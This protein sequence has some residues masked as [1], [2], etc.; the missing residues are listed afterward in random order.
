ML[1]VASG[2]SW[3]V[4]ES[5][6]GLT[7]VLHVRPNQPL[8]LQFLNQSRQALEMKMDS[9]AAGSAAVMRPMM[10]PQV[11]SQVRKVSLSTVTAVDPVQGP[12]RTWPSVN[13]C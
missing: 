9:P 8:S 13:V 2:P 4:L 7:R 3:V 1:E 12:V 5:C 6:S 11:T 10:Q